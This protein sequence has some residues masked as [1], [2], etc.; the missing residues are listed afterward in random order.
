VLYLL[1]GLV[2]ESPIFTEVHFRFVDRDLNEPGEHRGDAFRI[3]L[4]FIGLSWG[5]G[6]APTLFSQ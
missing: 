5:N 3:L 6:Q 4:L 2:G 1:D